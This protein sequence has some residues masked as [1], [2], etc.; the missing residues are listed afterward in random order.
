VEEVDT[1]SG[2]AT[3]QIIPE[4]GLFATVG[5]IRGSSHTTLHP[6]ICPFRHPAAYPLKRT[7]QQAKACNWKKNKN[8]ISIF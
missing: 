8:I 5:Y 2:F 4:P 6:S 3:V 7:A 1:R